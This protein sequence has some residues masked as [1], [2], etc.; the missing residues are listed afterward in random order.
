MEMSLTHH[1]NSIKAQIDNTSSNDLHKS[2]ILKKIG[3]YVSYVVYVPQPRGL[4]IGDHSMQG[5]FLFLNSCVRRDYNTNF[6]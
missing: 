2:P 4:D 6:L 3:G 1:F 5:V